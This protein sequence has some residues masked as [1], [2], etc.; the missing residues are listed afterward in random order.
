MRTTFIAYIDESGDEG[1]SFGNGSSDWFVLSAAVVRSDEDLKM[2]ALTNGVKHALN[3][4]IKKPLHFRD[5]RHHHRVLYTNRI[6]AASLRTVSILIHKPSVNSPEAFNERYRLYFYAVR[7]LCE[8][9]SWYCRDHKKPADNGDG[10]IQLV[11]SNRSSMSYKEMGDYL[12]LLERMSITLSD[13]IRVDWDTVDPKKIKTFTAGKRAG[14]QVADAIASSFYYAAQL[15]HLGFNE[16]RYARIL[17]PVTYRHKGRSQGYGV[18][19]FPLAADR[20]V[21]AHAHLGWATSGY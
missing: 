8:R 14:L 9:I 11:F 20:L 4:S 13:D 15:S 16:D 21:K 5:L 19:F 6:A 10:T 2:V 1:F 12:N 7:L 17:A 18:K 3:K